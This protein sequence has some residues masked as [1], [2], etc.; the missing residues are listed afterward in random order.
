MATAAQGEWSHTLVASPPLL[1]S[2]VD[3]QW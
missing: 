3:R 2:V 1:S